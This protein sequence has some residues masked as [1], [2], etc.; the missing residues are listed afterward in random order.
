[1]KKLCILSM[2]LAILVFGC[3][4]AQVKTD[5]VESGKLSWTVQINK[6]VCV[7][8]YSFSDVDRTYYFRTNVQTDYKELAFAILKISGVKSVAPDYYTLAVKIAKSYTWDEI[9]P[10]ILEILDNLEYYEMKGI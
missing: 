5:A 10:R 7:E 1:M 6:N 2:I 4:V 3:Q 9:E 8:H